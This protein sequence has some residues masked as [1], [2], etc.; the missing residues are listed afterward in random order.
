MKVGIDI[1]HLSARQN[2]G[3][4]EY[5]INLIDNLSALYPNTEFKI[6]SAGRSI[7]NIASRWQKK[8]NILLKHFNL[9]NRFLDSA[10]RFSKKPFIDNLLG[11]VDV[12][13][14]PH[15][16][17][18]SLSSRCPH[19]LVMHDL[20]FIRFPELF[21]L[22]DKIWHGLM[23]PRNQVFKAD[24]II[25]VS[26]STKKDLINI[27]NIPE[28]KINVVHSGIDPS[29]TDIISQDNRK[30]MVRGKYNL[31]A[32]FILALSAVE[33]RKNHVNLIRAFT[34]LKK[35][36]IGFTKDVFLVIAGSYSKNNKIFQEAK[37]S[38]YKDS[39][40]FTGFIDAKD[41][42]FIYD[43]AR[44][45]VYPSL[46]EG[47]GFPPLEAMSRGIPTIVSSRSSLPE[48]TDDAAVNVDPYNIS[49]LALVMKEL[50]EDENIRQFLSKKGKIKAAE[51]N[52]N[53]TASAVYAILEDT[54]N[55]KNQ[56][57]S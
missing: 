31:P 50:F 49:A 30:E 20:S 32:N 40:L 29:F 38:P 52:W 22:S 47:F 15:F 43:L 11:G 36:H 42:P 10:L 44:I 25:A 55:Q 19:V 18:T 13:L 56:Q 4:A 23:N 14:S 8:E 5:T 46:F 45:F 28:S 37:S 6:F 53:K 39:I 26:H 33:P 24:H 34:E 7:P 27:W 2:G 17:L 12:F 21:S 16:L 35:R 48:I 41:K 54:I 3:I 9:P 51:Y 1:R 57:I